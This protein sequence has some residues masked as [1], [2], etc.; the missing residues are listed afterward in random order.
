MDL[1]T[2]AL[3]GVSA[4]ATA[5]SLVLAQRQRYAPAV[6]W[7]V[8]AAL[9]L[10][11]ALIGADPFLHD[12]D[13]R[14]HALVAKNMLTTGWARPLL[15][16][17]PLLPY[18]YQQWCC[19]HVWL[20]KQPL[21][22]WQ[23]A[24]S[25]KLFGVSAMAVRLP[26]A[27]LGSLLLW[28]VYRLGR[29]VFSPAVGYHAALL[30][31]FAYYQLELTTGWQSVDHSDVAFACYVAGSV[32]AYYESRQPHASAWWCGLV[33]LLA[34]AAVLCKW[35]PGLVVYA[36]WGLELVVRPDYRAKPSEYARL[37]AAI[38][39]TLLV[40]LPWQ[41][42]IQQQFPVES[43]FERSYS[44]QHFGQVLEGQG[45]PWYFYLTQN[46]WYQY[47]WLVLLLGGGLGLLC[48]AP[49]R[50][51]PVRP[52]LVS[53]GV[54]FGFFSVAATKMPSYTYAVGPL[55]LVVAAVA[56][57][58]GLAW[59]RPRLGRWGRAGAAAGSC[60]VLVLALRPSSLLKHHTDRLAA[61]PA[62]RQRKVQ[63][64]TLYKQLDGLVPAG[65]VVFGVPALEEIEAMFYSRQNV[66]AGLPSQAEYRAL[67]AQGVR[68]AIFLPAGW[69]ALPP[70]LATPEVRL[71]P[72]R[73]E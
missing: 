72:G 3:L 37:L 59:L 53:C 63:H 13:E 36:S 69:Q 68:I 57:V 62:A 32:W 61:E 26:S 39:I 38:G 42:Y 71:L 17:H 50:R 45:G 41:L 33:G 11:L 66:Y 35:L 7:L 14:F 48:T 21:F 73:L 4:G 19:N 55:L 64:T 16:A 65:Y 24:L 51:R 67:R 15:R 28:P 20:H 5:I 31:A 43:T 18:D 60:L 29:L 25:L 52:L 56:W 47:Q 30:L 40:V 8:A 46:M 34:G 22:L 44:A 9:G 27:L 58:A 10:R 54:L 2:L 49:Y 6:C 23:M 12:W 1:V 70:Y